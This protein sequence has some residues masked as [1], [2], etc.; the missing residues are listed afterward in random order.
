[1]AR[2]R[3]IKLWMRKEF[4]AL[5]RLLTAHAEP[6]TADRLRSLLPDAEVLHAELAAWVNLLTCDCH[7]LRDGAGSR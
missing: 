2:S 3:P 6:D 7:G 1:M 4:A 5:I